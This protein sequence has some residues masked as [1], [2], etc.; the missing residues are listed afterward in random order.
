[1][2]KSLIALAVLGAAASAQAADI[3]LYGVVINLRFPKFD[4]INEVNVVKNS[5]SVCV[6]LFSSWGI[7]IAPTLLYVFL[8]SDVIGMTAYLG[9]C[10]AALLVACA[11]LYLKL[12]RSEERFMEL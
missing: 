10:G 7:L 3:S 4:Y 1:M 11:L 6:C 12:C 8:L 9:I 2:K 5:L